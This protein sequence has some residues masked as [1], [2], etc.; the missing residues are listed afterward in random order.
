MK[1]KKYIYNQQKL[2]MNA[3]IALMCVTYLCS[4]PYHANVVAASFFSHSYS[5]NLFFISFSD[6]E[7]VNYFFDT[8]SGTTL[9][10]NYKIDL[11]MNSISHHIMLMT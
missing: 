10:S 4:D 9:I 5:S 2:K 6:L 11:R 7:F 1:Q 8:Q 3:M